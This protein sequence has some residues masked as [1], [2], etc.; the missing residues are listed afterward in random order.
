MFCFFSLLLQVAE[1]TDNIQQ[2]VEALQ[3]SPHVEVQV[4][5]VLCV[6]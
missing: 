1:L 6:L 3:N 2:I 5:F 4:F